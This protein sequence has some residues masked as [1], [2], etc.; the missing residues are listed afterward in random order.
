MNS[1]RLAIINWKTT[2]PGGLFVLCLYLHSEPDALC[3]LVSASL[4]KQIAGWASV[5]T[6]LATFAT[7]K[8]NNVS[9]NGTVSNP[10]KIANGDGT[11]TIVSPS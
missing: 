9:G 7:S 6:G 5:V 10:A 4:A 11:N 1:L 8:A 3:G 2:L